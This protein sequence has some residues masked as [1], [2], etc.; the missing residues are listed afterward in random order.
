MSVSS[1]LDIYN[2]IAQA[3]PAL[4][5]SAPHTIER[6]AVRPLRHHCSFWSR[7]LRVPP[8]RWRFQA[9]PSPYPSRPQPFQSFASTLHAMNADK[10]LQTRFKSGGLRFPVL[11][12]DALGYLGKLM[13]VSAAKRR[14]GQM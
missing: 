14:R 6:L 4:E 13:E 10:E 12:D 7:S 2:V 5:A 3:A 9:P 8:A 11:S 1:Y